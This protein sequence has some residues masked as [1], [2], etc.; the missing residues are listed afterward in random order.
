MRLSD[1][2][3]DYIIVH[4]LVHTMI[5]N[6]GADFKATLQRHFP[7]SAELDKELKKIKTGVY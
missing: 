5:Q 4:E 1:R 3:I 6:H 2:L 7:D